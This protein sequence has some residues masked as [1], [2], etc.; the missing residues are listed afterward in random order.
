MTLAPAQSWNDLLTN[1]TFVQPL[2]DLVQPAHLIGRAVPPVAIPSLLHEL[3]HHSCLCS[4][5]GTALAATDMKARRLAESGGEE[6]LR[7]A[8]TIVLTNRAVVELYRPLLEGLALFAEFD[9]LPGPSRIVSRPLLFTARHTSGPEKSSE[10][11][12]A[13]VKTL[14]DARQ[15]RV[16]I[17]RRRNL[18]GT[19]LRDPGGH[20]LGY[21]YVKTWGWWASQWPIFYDPDFVLFFL[22]EYFWNDYELAAMLL[23]EHPREEVL[24]SKAVFEYC[25]HR[26][27]SIL[28]GETA[29]EEIGAHFEQ[30][31]LDY[32]LGPAL[33]PGIH[34]GPL[35]LPESG[36][37]AGRAR[38]Q[39]FLDALPIEDKR[40]LSRRSLLHL[41]SL[42]V[43]T[44]L[45]ERPD[46]R[47]LKVSYRDQ[48][49]A[50]TKLADSYSGADGPATFDAFVEAATH[51]PCIAIT[52]K[53]ELAHL[54]SPGSR[55]D[56]IAQWGRQ[57]PIPRGAS[58]FE[59]ATVAISKRDDGWV[60]RLGTSFVHGFR[61]VLLSAYSQ[62]GL[63]WTTPEGKDA[64]LRA[65]A[66]FRSF[67]GADLT[68]SLAT[69]ASIDC[70]YAYLDEVDP[71]EH[72]EKLRAAAAEIERRLAPLGI[73]PIS[74]RTH[75]D[76]DG[77]DQTAV[78]IRA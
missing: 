44:E 70:S 26:L 51:E 19:G 16:S 41:A 29:W 15:M 69:L 75:K 12:L 63:A 52:V 57:F 9:A 7:R 73:N 49:L 10:W 47:L 43:E 25:I 27:A 6:D 31:M 32:E 2:N 8:S 46:G 40:A 39:E 72:R 13:L 42:A 65:P 77:R 18:L 22:S 17:E 66:G 5:V 35:A 20:Q 78:G 45:V 54:S 55:Q 11:E 62:V 3:A 61:D 34:L 38:L 4:A 59:P 21:Q 33:G 28:D 30:A 36:Q 76:E 60:E 67:L 56:F 50:V 24:P 23:D 37:T 71:E 74:I 68:M 53:G 64:L 58:G 14:I 1:E 48:P